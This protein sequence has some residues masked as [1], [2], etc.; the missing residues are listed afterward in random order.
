MSGVSGAIP[1]PCGD[2]MCKMTGVTECRICL[3]NLANKPPKE[4]I[5]PNVARH[6]PV[7]RKQIEAKGYAPIR[8]CLVIGKT[9]FLSRKDRHQ[10]L[11]I[12][13]AENN[14]RR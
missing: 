6:L 11:R 14:Y 3:L 2:Y 4:H 1:M 8:K 10:A 9:N 12:L 13:D 7:L 5:R